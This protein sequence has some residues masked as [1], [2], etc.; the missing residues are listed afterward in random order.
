MTQHAHTDRNRWL[1][2][3]ALCA[4]GMLMVLDGTIVNVAL[5][6]IRHDLGVSP[7]N[8]AWI[9]NAYMIAFGAVLL[10]G[11]RL[12]DLIG[13]R[14]VFVAGLA[15]FTLAS[16]LCALAPSEGVLIAARALQGIGGG[17]TSSVVLG[18]IV[19]LFP[20]PR[21]QAKAIGVNG[22]IVS[23]GGAIGLLVG[24]VLTDAI[25][26][27]W[28]FL[29]NVPVGVAAVLLALRFVDHHRGVGLRRGPI[30]PARS[31]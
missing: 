24:G 4:G 23:A 29:V 20:A 18:M 13:R 17:L 16:P 12:G 14:R 10:L 28:I 22:F 6:S 26:W 2:L 31:S 5:P 11:G 7:E 1:A 21:E 19:T 30:C 27:H 9:V 25:S 8:L 15:T 3:S